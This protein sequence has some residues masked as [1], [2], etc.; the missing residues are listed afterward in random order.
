MRVTLAATAFR[1]A[2][3]IGSLVS[4]RRTPAS[5]SSGIIE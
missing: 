5:P 1:R 3:V 2:R 4:S